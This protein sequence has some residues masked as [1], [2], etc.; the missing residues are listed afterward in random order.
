VK[1]LSR[2][3]GKVAGD[4]R[5]P[6]VV[7]ESGGL[8]SL[9]IGGVAVQSAMRLDD[10][11]A[12]ALD[13]TRC[14]MAFLLFHPEPREALMVGL[15]G[16]SLAKFLHRELRSLRVRVV[17][18]DSRVIAA[19]R[20]HFHVPPD[21]ARLTVEVGCGADALAPECC[22]LLIV[23]GFLDETLPDSLASPPFFD[24]AWMALTEPG[25]LVMNLMDSDPR[26]DDVLR[27]VE[28]AFAGAVLCMPALRDPNVIVLA[29]KGAPAQIAWQVLRERAEPLEAR[30]GLPFARYLNAL[31]TM[32][33]HTAEELTVVGEAGASP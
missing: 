9:H 25:V 12:L 20:A 8:R 13:Y 21:D 3:K 30:L 23:D 16:G 6:V 7:S 33:P 28:H 27:H 2:L 19:A 26:F 31:R 4:R 1:A 32:N 15:G 22:D 14:M 10:P 29:L 24:A 5:P 18:I 17:E 11:Y